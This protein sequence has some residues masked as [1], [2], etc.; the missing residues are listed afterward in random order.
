MFKESQLY[1]QALSP[2]KDQ[3]ADKSKTLKIKNN[4]PSFLNYENPFK[5][6]VSKD[7]VDSESAD[8]SNFEPEFLKNNDSSGDGSEWMDLGKSR[9][10]V[11]YSEIFKAKNKP[12]VQQN[13]SVRLFPYIH[14]LNAQ[15]LL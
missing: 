11:F 5:N 7:S 12:L 1:S 4:G 2:Q 3:N 13:Q 15:N 8:V 14:Y 9:D 10:N 6:G